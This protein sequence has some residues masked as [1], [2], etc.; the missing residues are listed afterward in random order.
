MYIDSVILDTIFVK[1][2]PDLDKDNHNK[3]IQQKLECN[4]Y[5]QLTF[6]IK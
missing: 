1:P 3:L 2:R 5:S 4:I 6:T